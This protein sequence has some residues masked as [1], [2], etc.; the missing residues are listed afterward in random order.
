MSKWNLYEAEEL[1]DF[2]HSPYAL[3]N[4]DPEAVLEMRQ[5]EFEKADNIYNEVL[6]IKN[7]LTPKPIEE[8]FNKEYLN[9]LNEKKEL[10]SSVNYLGAASEILSADIAKTK[11]RQEDITL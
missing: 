3:K 11:K 7:N 2:A 1:K 8:R 10:I 4:T 6:N 9:A 5:R